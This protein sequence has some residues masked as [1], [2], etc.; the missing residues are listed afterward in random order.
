MAM[1]LE[2]ET[3]RLVD[4][5]VQHT[6]AE[7]EELLALVKAESYLNAT[8]ALRLGFVGQILPPTSNTIRNF[9][10]KFNI[11]EN[12]KVEELEAGIA[13][14]DSWLAKIGKKLGILNLDAVNMDMT[15]ATGAKFSIE[16]E[17][18]E[19]TVGD[20]ASPDGT[21][22]MEDGTVIV[23]A[24]GAIT[25]ITPAEE[26]PDEMEALKTENETLK[27]EIESL[28]TA[29]AQELEADKAALVAELT[30]AKAIKVELQGLKSKF[31][32]EARLSTEQEHNVSS[33]RKEI[34]RRKA[35]LENRK[36]K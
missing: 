24:G 27:A 36:K 30:E 14:H 18:G 1:D 8:E 20:I 2:Q 33:T 16:K 28:K 34:E 4:F 11:M 13:K 15:D 22:T 19:P 21:F 29:N 5:Y 25:E 12:K 7:R 31:F 32:P 9:K 3:N 10:E 6:G 26:T 23:I 17:S 35:E